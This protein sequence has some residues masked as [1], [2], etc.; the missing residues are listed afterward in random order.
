MSLRKICESSGQVPPES[1]VIALAIKHV[2]DKFQEFKIFCNKS[3]ITKT[4]LD[5]LSF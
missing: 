3:E 4:A 2:V 5:V 1:Q